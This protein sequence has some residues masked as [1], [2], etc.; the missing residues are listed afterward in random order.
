MNEFKA[1]HVLRTL[2]LTVLKDMGLNTIGFHE[3]SK[4]YIGRA[5]AKE[6]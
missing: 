1:Q 3:R 6:V 5:D 4:E 2:I